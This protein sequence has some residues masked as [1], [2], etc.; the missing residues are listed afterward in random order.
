VKFRLKA[1]PLVPTTHAVQLSTSFATIPQKGKDQI[2]LAW[3]LKQKKAV[4]DKTPTAF[5]FINI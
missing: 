1:E 3:Q 4:K 2:I 5:A